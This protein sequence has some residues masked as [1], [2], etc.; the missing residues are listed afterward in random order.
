MTYLDF[1]WGVF[2]L[3]LGLQQWGLAIVVLIVIAV[4]W[5]YMRQRRARC[6]Q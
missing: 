6:T 3:L 4:R 5:N 2:L 1:W